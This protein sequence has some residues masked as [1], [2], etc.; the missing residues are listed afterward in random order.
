MTV[1]FALA[2]AI[3]FGT[4]AFLMLKNDLIRVVAGI[5]LISNA[6]ILFIMATGLT[7]GAAPIYPLPEGATV[8]DPLVQA[9]V[10]T[11]I[12]ISFSVTALLLSLVYRVYRIYRVTHPDDDSA[13]HG[14]LQPVLQDPGEPEVLPE[15]ESAAC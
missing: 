2:V 5:I 14:L 10:L 8:S 1:L 13:H 6:A 3:L 15:Q 12:V 11:A 9:M 4:G 7:R